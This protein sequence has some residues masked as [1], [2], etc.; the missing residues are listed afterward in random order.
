M[1][2]LGDNFHQMQVTLNL[3]SLGETAPVGRR[4]GVCPQKFAHT[5]LWTLSESTALWKPSWNQLFHLALLLRFLSSPT[6]EL[7]SQGQVGVKQPMAVVRE[8]H[9]SIL[10]APSESMEQEYNG[11]PG[12]SLWRFQI[13]V[14]KSDVI[15]AIYM[16][17]ILLFVNKTRVD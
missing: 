1:N 9:I 6:R 4:Q 10:A 2:H 12:G 3:S 15:H 13:S 14:Y 11:S 17:P 5:S 16:G 7:R 8:T